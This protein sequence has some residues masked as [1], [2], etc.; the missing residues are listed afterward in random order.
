MAAATGEGIEALLDAAVEHLA[1]LAD[2][3]SQKREAQGRLWLSRA[4]R[5]ELGRR[6]AERVRSLTDGSRS[7]GSPFRQLTSLLQ[8]AD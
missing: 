3:L 7:G 1:W 5:E 8:H 6:G 4:V 2:G